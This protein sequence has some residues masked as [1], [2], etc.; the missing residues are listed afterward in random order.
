MFTCIISLIGFCLVAHW[1]KEV[2]HTVW[3]LF[4]AKPVDLGKLYGKN[5]YVIIT[6]GSKGI[7]FGLAKE[8]AKQNFNLVLIA[9]NKDDLANAKDELMKFNKNIDVIT[10]S[11]DFNILGESGKE[12]NMWE[13]LDLSP[14][15]D[16][17]ILVNNVGMANKDILLNTNEETIKRLITVNCTSQTVMSHMMTNYF[18]KRGKLSCIMT[19]SSLST[20]FPFPAYE[21][22]GASKSFNRYFSLT[23]L[24][25]PLVDSYT[26]CPAYVDTSLSRSK[27]NWFKVTSSECAESA[28]KFL[29][30]HRVEFYGHW[31]HELIHFAFKA[32]PSFVVL[33]ISQRKIKMKNQRAIPK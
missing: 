3:I 12:H 33:F 10:R 16:Y 28:I 5:S 27:N 22:Y 6:G 2:L 29:G 32:L 15:L 18:N 19:T 13:L 26:F 20:M 4:F 14:N 25:N 1:L 7:G 31:K 23:L 8:F 9:R 24:D 11:F 30:R 17:S 21:L